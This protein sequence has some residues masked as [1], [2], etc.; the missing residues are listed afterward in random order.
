MNF[1]NIYQIGKLIKEMAL[2][3]KD[4]Y[5]THYKR[6]DSSRY[7]VWKAVREF[8]ENRADVG[9]KRM[10][11][12]SSSLYTANKTSQAIAA[13]ECC[14]A[15]VTV[16]NNNC[17]GSSRKRANITKDLPYK[18]ASWQIAR[19]KANRKCMW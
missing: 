16:C 18:S 12:N 7:R 8:V 9:V 5:N 3:V 15:A 14:A 19:A 6:F 17:K 11:N 13:Q 1:N 4:F 2:R 10:P